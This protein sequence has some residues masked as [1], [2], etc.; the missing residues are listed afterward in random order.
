M[1]HWYSQLRVKF[2]RRI[3][4]MINELLRI[5]FHV[6]VVFL[7][8]QN[9]SLVINAADLK[10]TSIFLPFNALYYTVRSK[11]NSNTNIDLF[12]QVQEGP[13]FPP[14]KV[15]ASLLTYLWQGDIITEYNL[16][17][18][19]PRLTR[20]NHSSNN[21]TPTT[22]NSREP[23]YRQ[24]SLRSPNSISWMRSFKIWCSILAECCCDSA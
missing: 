14:V 22:E 9:F 16:L 7:E 13:S 1:Q 15:G 24:I 4:V 12:T 5:S 11:L 10:L 19:W 8:I 3:L 17:T 6:E 21:L 18:D 23:K 20:S 2:L